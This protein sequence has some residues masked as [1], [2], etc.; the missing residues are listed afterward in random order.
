[1]GLARRKRG[2]SMTGCRGKARFGTA[3]EATRE[4]GARYAYL[5][6]S[7]RLLARVVG[8]VPHE[9]AVTAFFDGL[10]YA[11]AAWAQER[12]MLRVRI[13]GWCSPKWLDIETVTEAHEV[14]TWARQ[15]TMLLGLLCGHA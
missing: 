2:R 14:A 11:Y 4:T 9:A 8:A 5:C 10:V 15:S 7:C 1:M 12:L 6:P 3:E 13:L